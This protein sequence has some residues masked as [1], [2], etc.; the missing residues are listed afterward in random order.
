MFD[1]HE[2][3]R[4]AAASVHR[5]ENDIKG[6]KK[7]AEGGFN[8]IF[9]ITMEGDGTQVLARLPYPSTVPRR[10]VVANEVATLDLVRSHDIPVPKV[11]GYSSNPDNPVGSEYIIMEKIH[12]G[13]PIGDSWYTF[14]DKERLKVLM[15]LVQLEAKLLAIDL[16]ASGGLYYS[17]DLPPE[18]NRV[19]IPSLQDSDFTAGRG[20]ICVGPVSSLKWWYGERALLHNINRGPRKS[21][22]PLRDI[23]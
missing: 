10:L 9:E 1:A 12:H 17:C 5:H 19:G 16:P 3:K 7:L 22:S 6:F 21:P 8:R 4:V 2:L 15:G 20:D 11:L 23:Y 14:S 13:N 18:M